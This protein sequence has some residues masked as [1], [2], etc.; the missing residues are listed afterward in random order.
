MKA[1]KKGERELESIQGKNKHEANVE[2]KGKTREI[3]KKRI[4][5]KLIIG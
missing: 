1:R 2:N 4:R 3:T 5:V